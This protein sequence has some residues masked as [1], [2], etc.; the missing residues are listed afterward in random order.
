VLGDFAPMM[1]DLEFALMI[2]PSIS[3]DSGEYVTI[4]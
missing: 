4:V 2:F 3:G 1:N